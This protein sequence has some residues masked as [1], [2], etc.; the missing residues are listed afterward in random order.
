[1]CA[2]QYSACCVCCCCCCCLAVCQAV[3]Q[4]LVAYRAQGGPTPSSRLTD[5]KH[6]KL[7]RSSGVCGLSWAGSDSVR[8]WRT[9]AQHAEGRYFEGTRS[10]MHGLVR[11]TDWLTD[12][13]PPLRVARVGFVLVLH[14]RNQTAACLVTVQLHCEGLQVGQPLTQIAATAHHSTPQQATARHSTSCHSLCPGMPPC[15]CKKSCGWWFGCYL[16][17]KA[18]CSSSAP[19]PPLPLFPAVPPPQLLSCSVCGDALYTPYNAPAV[20]MWVDWG[21]DPVPA[22]RGFDMDAFTAQPQLDDPAFEQ[23]VQGN[24]SRPVLL[25]LSALHGVA[26]RKQHGLMLLPVVRQAFWC[27]VAVSCVA[28]LFD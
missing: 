21:A 26:W 19:H 8:L 12:H 5:W 22:P 11:P 28:T 4:H 13:H 6:L 15:F 25:R 3:I 18:L 9:F 14:R 23:R 7:H 24:S 1:M 20:R 16:K 10:D 2:S 27:L 17:H